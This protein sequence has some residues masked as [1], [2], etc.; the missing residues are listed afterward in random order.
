MQNYALAAGLLLSLLTSL[1]MLQMSLLG[2][3]CANV[4]LEPVT[5]R[6]INVID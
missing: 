2:H 5:L 3:F 4:P 1:D 6:I